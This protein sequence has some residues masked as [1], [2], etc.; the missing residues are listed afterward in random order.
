MVKNEK[1]RLGG[2]TR[3]LRGYLDLGWEGIVPLLRPHPHPAK[4]QLHLP[5]GTPLEAEVTG[6]RLT[7]RAT[8]QENTPPRVV[9]ALGTI[10]SQ[11]SR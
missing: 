2:Q 10:L 3:L 8:V 9:L 11:F 5:R 6:W 7:G 4:G 1:G